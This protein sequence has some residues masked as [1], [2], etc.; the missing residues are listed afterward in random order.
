MANLETT[1][2]GMKLHSPIVVASAAITETVE[3][4][5]RCQ[6]HGAGA[7]V[8]KSYFEEEVCR[9]APTPRFKVI[10]HVLGN[11]KSFTFSSYEQ[12][13]E[14]DI[15]RYA[16]EVTRA[17]DTLEIKVIP[18]INCVTE[19][20]W[21]ESA[22]IL[23][24]A[25]ADALVTGDVSHHQGRAA[26]DSGLAVVDPGHAATERPGVRRLYAAVA[27]LVPE[28]RDLGDLTADPWRAT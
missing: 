20:G 26:V 9:T 19:K 13:S 2:L 4:L 27:E 28:V 21:V 7:A 25:G 11:E 3:R 24:A 18:S 15:H 17:K 10:H 12:A 8:M 16:Q 23:E 1:Y 14:W 22:M 6:D 5:Q